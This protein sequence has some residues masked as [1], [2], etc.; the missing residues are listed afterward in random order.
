M[1]SG[2]RDGIVALQQLRVPMDSHARSG[3]VGGVEHSKR[4]PPPRAPEPADRDRRR[5]RDSSNA[6]RTLPDEATPPR[7][8]AAYAPAIRP[9]TA[10]ADAP[11]PAG[12]HRGELVLVP[13]LGRP[14]QPVGAA[15]RPGQ[16]E[17]GGD[18]LARDGPGRLQDQR[19]VADPHP[20][21]HRHPLLRAGALGE[22]VVDGGGG[23]PPALLQLAAG[24]LVDRDVPPGRVGARPAVQGRVLRTFPGQVV[25]AQTAGRPRR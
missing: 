15:A 14:G 18:A 20:A 16:G 17:P 11:T 1:P 12:S 4:T 7:R 19:L 5:A 21:A 2:P 13:V 25:V 8:S 10:T 6:A 22:A 3:P 23:D 24:Q 9:R